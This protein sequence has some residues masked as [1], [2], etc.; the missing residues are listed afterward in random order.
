[1]T[2]SDA[3]WIVIADGERARF[4]TRSGQAAFHTLKIVQA[5]EPL[6]QLG[7][8]DRALRQTPRQPAQDRFAALVAAHLNAAAGA[9]LFGRLV[10]AAPA[11]VLQVL[12]ADLDDPARSRLICRIEQD[13]TGVPDSALASH[14]PPGPAKG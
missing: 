11:R 3:E 10:L 8:G 5:S 7:Y 2:A 9:G 4:M 14:L 1:M 13:L 6:A 12:E